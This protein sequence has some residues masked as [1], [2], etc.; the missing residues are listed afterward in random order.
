[1]E[2]EQSTQE[3]GDGCKLSYSGA[4]MQDGN[5]TDTFLSKN[6]K[7]ILAGMSRKGVRGD[8]H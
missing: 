1:M 2:G 7:H 3:L 5:G 4:S 8:E 6:L